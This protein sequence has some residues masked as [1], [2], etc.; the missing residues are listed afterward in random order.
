RALTQ[1]V[2][3]ATPRALQ[4]K[5][6]FV[7][8]LFLLLFRIYSIKKICFCFTLLFSTALYTPIQLKKRYHLVNASLKDLLC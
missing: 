8:I 4:N 6:L 5:C 2:K 3:S 1:A 7:F